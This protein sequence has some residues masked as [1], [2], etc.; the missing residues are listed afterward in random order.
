MFVG[1]KKVQG[2]DW[3]K[4]QKC[5]EDSFLEKDQT[6]RILDAGTNNTLID[7]DIAYWAKYGSNLFPSIVINNSTYRGQIETQGV[8]NAICAGF[9]DPPRM[10][11]RILRKNL[12]NDL[13][14]GVMIFDDGYKSRHIAG[15]F[16]IFTAGL[17]ITL[18][19]Y[20]R[21]AKRQMKQVMSQ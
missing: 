10:C 6:K 9:Q 11:K 3:K 19:C 15:I 12:E 8:M 7:K 5:V 21:H 2:L 20:R 1:H 16:L 4:T 13:L 17:L 14:S 18:C